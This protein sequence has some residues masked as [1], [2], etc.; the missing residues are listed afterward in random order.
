MYLRIKSAEKR[1]DMMGRGRDANG[2]VADRIRRKKAGEG[3]QMDML[4]IIRRKKAGHQGKGKGCK[5]ICCGSADM[6][7]IPQ[8][9]C[10]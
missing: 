6:L 10:G 7:R 4:R 2:Y 9:C 3:M 8:I 5:R 1:R